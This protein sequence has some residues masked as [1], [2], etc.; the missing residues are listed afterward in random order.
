MTKQ[1]RLRILLN[2]LNF[3]FEA[4]Q[5]SI[6]QRWGIVKFIPK[7]KEGEQGWRKEGE[8]GWRSG[9]CPRLPPTWPEFGPR[10]G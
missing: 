6:S 10:V 5:L 4:G 7:N 1:K 2:A 8:Q 3:S 9:D